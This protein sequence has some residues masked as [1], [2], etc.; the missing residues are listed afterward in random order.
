[1][2]GASAPQNIFTYGCETGQEILDHFVGATLGLGHNNII[3]PTGP[4]FVISPEHAATMARDGIGKREIR[5]AVFEHARI[6]LSRFAERSV[7][8]LQ[9]RRARWFAEVGDPDH[10][11][12]ADRPEDISIVVAGGAGIH[13]LFVPT[14]FSY[15][16]VTRQIVVKTVSKRRPKK[17]RADR[18][19]GRIAPMSSRRPTRRRHRPQRSVLSP[20]RDAPILRAMGIWPAGV[21][22][23]VAI[24]LMP[25]PAGLSIAG[26]HMLGIFAFAVIVWMTEA[27]DYAASSVM[28]L[29]LM[30]FL[31]GTA[32][33]PAHPDHVLGTSAGAVGGD[34][35]LHQSGGGADRG[36]AR[37]CQR[38]WPLPASTSASRSS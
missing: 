37:H 38:R 7:E 8:G 13:S 14:A 2:I 15:R 32:P 30:A 18:Q 16:A 24:V 1:M 31:L 22:A 4:L 10:I 23:L 36:F 34:G 29:A 6:P 11:G 12:V 20:A 28:L 26:Q 17:S 35:R 27:V 3:F 9:H 33:D 25:Q 5:D 21:A 19:F